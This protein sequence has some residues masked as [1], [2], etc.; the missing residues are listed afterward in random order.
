MR[1]MN[2]SISMSDHALLVLSSDAGGVHS[3]APTI[4][5]YP[6]LGHVT[7]HYSG[8]VTIEKHEDLHRC[9]NGIENNSCA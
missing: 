3:L 7:F 1:A 6:P 9:D 4:G 8:R 2:G 5:W